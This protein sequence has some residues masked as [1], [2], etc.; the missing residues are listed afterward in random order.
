MLERGEKSI[1]KERKGGEK[2][3]VDHEACAIFLL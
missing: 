3:V 2:G 1:G